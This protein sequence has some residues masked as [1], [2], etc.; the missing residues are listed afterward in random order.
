[1]KNS[2]QL[3]FLW[4]ISKSLS[5]SYDAEKIVSAIEQ[6]LKKHI[7][8]EKAEILIWDKNTKNVKNF[9]KSWI[10]INKDKQEY[11]VNQ[12]FNT[13][14]LLSV[15]CSCSVVSHSLQPHGLELL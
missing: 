13:F 4:D 9:A 3:D 11:Y 15:Q 12:I 10:T 14:E 7:N 2:T 5:D 6:E 1:M 8:C